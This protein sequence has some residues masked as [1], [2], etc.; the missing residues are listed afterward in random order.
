MLEQ[1]RGIVQEVNAAQ[2][3]QSALD[4]IVRRVRES[5][6]TEVCSIFLYDTDLNAHV[7]MASEGLNKEA[8]GHVSLAVGEGL[9]G[10]VAKHAEPINLRDASTH[11]SFHYI[12]ETGEE[13]F[14][15]FL[16]VP[17]IH[18]RNVL[19]VVVVQHAQLRGFDEGEEAFLI[20]LSAQLAGVI[21]SAEATGAIEGVSPSGHKI[22]DTVFGG[23][24]GASGVAIG[25]IVV[26]FPKA[27][28]YQVPV[29]RARDIDQEIGYFT[30]SLNKVRDDMRN[31]HER[32]AGRVAEEERQLFDVYL[33]M[34]DDDAL[35]NEVVERI[36]SGHW[37]QGAL[38]E[39]AREHVRTFE[40]MSDEYLRERA[41]DIKDLCSRVLFYLQ[42]GEQVET[43]YFED[44]ILVGEEVTPAMLAEVSKSKLKGIVSVK[45]SGN[46]HV[47][48]LARTMGIPT[49]M[50]VV[51]LPINQLDGREVILDGY[52][53]EIIGNP[54]DTVRTRYE[55]TIK[56]QAELI[57]DLEELKDL[58]CITADDH[59]VHLWVNTGLI[60]DVAHSLDQGAE[61]V[62]LF[63]TEVP[64]LL[65]ER[66][67]SEQE[68]TDIYREQLAAFSPMPVTM[69]TLDIGGDKALSY[70]P[71][72]E[73]NPF[74][75]WR[76]IRVTLDHP[77]I[78]TAQIRA[79]MRASIGLE[80]LQIMLPMISNVNE[81][82][83]SMQLIKKAHREL[84][85]EGLEVKFPPVG[86][87]IEVPAAVYQTRA[88][89]SLVDFVSVGSND[90]TQYL[91]AVDRNN[92]R[93]A[94]LYSAFHPA[95]LHALYHV[96]SEA[97][98]V[99]KQVSICGEMA[100]DP[101]AAVLLLAMGFDVLSM[102]AA[103]LLKVK[104]VIRSVS[105]DAA[106]DL[107]DQVMQMDDAQ[108]IR[109]AVDL[110]LYN[111]GVDR[112]LRSSRTN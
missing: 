100:G 73:E 71:I 9:V 94:N 88:L 82:N 35:G 25:K 90:L 45:G 81:V 3:L 65:S 95:V 29:R 108:M 58:P 50:G 54:S 97:Q 40:M 77:E 60:A 47:A 57:A 107:L 23:V 49:V 17:I 11:P 19:G 28:L 46:S 56:E 31:M 30:S 80:N 69:R 106:Q 96:V 61:G 84:I 13:S 8:V 67:P 20:T 6:A 70:F 83:S 93:V 89:A 79:M 103:T 43:E 14:N 87:M 74:L 24:S 101:G 32:L 76:G 21:A 102:N 18:H 62:G 22:S 68:Q 16:G 92:P 37:A 86:V 85:Q 53:G 2:D 55:N 63:R 33:H 105:L 12:Q 10:L 78:F 66:F 4:I 75:G 111:A 98:K 52:K 5:L 42:Q 99:G 110:T 91:L 39:V 15:S 38:A 104:S 36:R 109:S 59:R 51:D 48:I 41:V 34:L 7:L 112:L 26:V 72:E 64:F 1:L 44:T 27:N